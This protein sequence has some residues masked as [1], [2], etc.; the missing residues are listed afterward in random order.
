MDVSTYNALRLGTPHHEKTEAFGDTGGGTNINDPSWR[1]SKHDPY[2]LTTFSKHH[3]DGAPTGA[4]SSAK[5][6]ESQAFP[7]T[8]RDTWL[9]VPLQYSNDIPANLLVCFDGGGYVD[10]FGVPTVLDNLIHRKEIP[11]TICVFLSPGKH[12]DYAE[13][14]SHE[15]DTVN[16]LNAQ[17]LTEEVLPPIE[18]KY[19]ISRDPKRRCVCGLSSGGI[20]AFSVAWFRPKSFGCVISWIGSFTNIRGGHNYPWLVRNTK[21]K[22]IKVFLQDGSNDLNNQH[23]SWPLANKEMHAALLYAGYNVRLEWGEGN[24]SG[25]HGAAVFPDTLRWMWPSLPPTGKL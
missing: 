13:Q 8:T 12:Q 19:N 14:R 9:Y 2:E 1:Q 20:A 11:A 16:G 23:G 10:R 24:H 25:T 22:P 18:A 21:R 5:I 4:V 3:I 17:F 7:G 15:Y 6:T